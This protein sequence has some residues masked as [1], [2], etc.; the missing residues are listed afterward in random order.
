MVHGNEIKMYECYRYILGFQPPACVSLSVSIS[1]STLLT[2]ISILS[3]ALNTL[4][5]R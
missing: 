3:L 5:C 4:L 2:S 1:C